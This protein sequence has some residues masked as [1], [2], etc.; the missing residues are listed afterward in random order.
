MC[1]ITGDKLVLI[2]KVGELE[3]APAILSGFTVIVPVALTVPHPPVKGILYV[4][5]PETVGVPEIVISLFNHEADTPVGKPV[6]VPI[7]V[8]PVVV[9]F[10]LFAK[11][12]FIHNGAIVKAVTVFCVLH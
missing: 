5:G 7:P 9:I 2:H 4:K 1:V 10:K 3:A 6:G 8:A 11:A 12:V